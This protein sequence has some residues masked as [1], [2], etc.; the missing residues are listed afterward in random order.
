MQL[1]KLLKILNY[2]AVG[3]NKKAGKVLFNVIKNIPIPTLSNENLTSYEMLLI[4]FW[5]YV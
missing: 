5:L 3:F 2:P 1:A 4:I